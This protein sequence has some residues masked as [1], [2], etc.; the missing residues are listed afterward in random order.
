[1]PTDSTALEQLKYPIGR[2]QWISNYSEEERAAKLKTIENLPLRLKELVKDWT[3]ERLNTPYRPDGWTVKQ[4]LHHIVDSH[5]NSYVRFK[6][7]MTEDKP[8]IKAYFEDRW[9]ELPDSFE[10]PIEISLNMLEWLHKRW[11]IL[12]RN[13][14]ENDW[15]RSFIHPE[16][17]REITLT[18]LMPLYA[19]HSE[20]HFQHINQLKI[21]MGW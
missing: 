3:P 19:W 14:S 20:H 17:G 5:M 16:S 21:R 11:L 7:T 18:E 4:L 12:M 2:F 8:T 15:N 6:W 9:A 13:L 10:T 1:M